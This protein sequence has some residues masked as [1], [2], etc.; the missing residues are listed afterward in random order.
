[1]D[2]YELTANQLTSLWQRAAIHWSQT[3]A[4]RLSQKIIT[5]SPFLEEYARQL[6]PSAHPTTLLTSLELPPT[7]TPLTSDTTH[8]TILYIGSL[9]IT[10][11][12]RIDLLPD[13]LAG[14]RQKFPHITL[15]LAGDG[16]DVA[17][18][19]Q[20]FA[21]K[22]L[23]SATEFTG[24]F[25]P[26]DLP[27][28]LKNVTLIIDPIDS[29]I[30]NRAKSS[31]R[32]ALAATLGLPIITSNVGVRDTW[33]P[34]QFHTRFFATPGD[35]ASYQSKVIAAL[36]DPLTQTQQDHFKNHAQTYTWAKIANTYYNHL[37]SL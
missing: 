19:K 4:L 23:S 34:P 13:I 37:K 8:P 11:G 32:A 21:T 16:D 12:H 24:R 27:E 26:K 30:T 29:S 15:R 17:T 14:V 31:Y 7:S 33:I 2:D 22:N 6:K 3:T 28:L 20:A 18:L 5:A 25:T 35:T 1:M 9:S 36:S 10:S